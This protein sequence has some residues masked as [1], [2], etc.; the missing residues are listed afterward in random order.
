M[1]VVENK[2]IQLKNNLLDGCFVCAEVECDCFN[3]FDGE[4]SALLVELLD[5]APVDADACTA[6][7]HEEALELGVVACAVVVGEVGGVL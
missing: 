6:V 1:G 2:Q 5:D 3:M 7:A 4:L